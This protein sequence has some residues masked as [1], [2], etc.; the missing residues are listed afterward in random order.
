MIAVLL[1]E[2]LVTGEPGM[3]RIASDWV[4]ALFSITTSPAN[5]RC[6]SSAMCSSWRRMAA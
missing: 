5:A 1:A 3:L 6:T 2:P 4:N